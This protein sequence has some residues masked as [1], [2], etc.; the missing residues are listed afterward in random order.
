MRLAKIRMRKGPI[1]VLDQE[2][3]WH[4]SDGVLEGLLN[5]SFEYDDGG[6]ALPNP[7]RAYVEEVAAEMGATV[8]EVPEES[9]FDPAVVY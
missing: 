5:A 2:M 7:V 8:E 3:V 9:E 4:S 1:A 6:G